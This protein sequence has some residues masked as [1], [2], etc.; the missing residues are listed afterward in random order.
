MTL[1]EIDSGESFGG[2][3]AFPGDLVDGEIEPDQFTR[4]FIG[5][6]FLKDLRSVAGMTNAGIEIENV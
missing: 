1:C 2:P 6:G 4:L 5:Q 3:D